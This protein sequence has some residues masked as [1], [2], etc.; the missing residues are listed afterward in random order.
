MRSFDM[1]KSTVIAFV[2]KVPHSITHVPLLANHVPRQPFPQMC[3]MNEVDTAM[4][5]TPGLLW[6]G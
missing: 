1:P 3:E 4:Q 5:V 2:K 6:L